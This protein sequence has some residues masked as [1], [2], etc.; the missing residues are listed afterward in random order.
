MRSFILIITLSLLGFF[1]QFEFW[2]QTGD[3][4]FKILVFFT[5]GYFLYKEFLEE[6]PPSSKRNTQEEEKPETPISP[7]PLMQLNLENSIGDDNISSL[8]NDKELSISTIV[9]SQFEI[10]YSFLMPANGY[11]FIEHPK[12]TVRL[13]F[14]KIK[15]NISWNDINQT[16]NLFKILKNHRDE[17]LVENNIK[18][19]SNILPFY[20]EDYSIQ[21]LFAQRILLGKD[22][23]IYFVFDSPE[24]GYFNTEDYNVPIQTSFILQFV[25]SNGVKR[26]T[27]IKEN[28]EEKVI[29]SLA[30][31]LN[32]SATVDDLISDYVEFLADVYEAHKLT[33]ALVDKNN[34]QMAE[35]KKSIGQVDS[36]KEGTRFAIDEGLC[37]KVILNDQVYLLD[38][39]EKDGYFIP[40]FSKNEKTNYGLRSF[41]AIPLK[42]NATSPIGMISL[43]HKNA[44]AFTSQHKFKLKMYTE[45][46]ESALARFE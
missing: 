9:L 3:T 33:I 46:F 16:P 35:I 22:Q 28:E 45:Y 38:N 20:K 10:L 2:G 23:A 24:A 37:G 29:I 12:D 44:N 41:L 6:P 17:I 7:L 39:I 15:P 19:P 1:I 40:R 21:S 13:F 5:L 43:E 26:K 14:K 36:I 34:Q 27:I 32:S 18:T 4:I 31:K 8:L 42:A 11:I 25:I 30:K